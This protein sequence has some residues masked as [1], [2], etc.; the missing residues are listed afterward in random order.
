VNLYVDESNQQAV[1]S[2][3]V[4][5]DNFF[6]EVGENCELQHGDRILI[7]QNYVFVYID[8]RTEEYVGQLLDKGTVGFEMGIIKWSRKI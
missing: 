6:F 2:T 1:N 8:H 7:G 4:N 5:G 3:F